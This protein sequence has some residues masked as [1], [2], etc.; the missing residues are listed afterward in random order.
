MFR[1]VATCLLFSFFLSLGAQEERSAHTF[2]DKNGKQ[3]LATLLSVSAD[4]R[5]MKIRREDGQEFEFV[6]NVLSLDDQQYIK[7][8]LETLPVEKTEYRLEMDIAKK[9]ISSDSHPYDTSTF[10]LEQEFLTYE[11]KVRNLS[12]EALEDAKVEWAV[13]IDDRVKVFQ[14]NGEWTYDRMGKEAE[15]PV[16]FSGEVPLASLPFNQEAIVT[17]GEVEVNE[18][19]R[20]RDVY[21]EADSIIGAV[22]RVVSK[23]GSVLAESRLGGA[24][25]GEMSWEEVLT[26]APVPVEP[27]D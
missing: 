27:A 7:E 25:F 1:F 20:D 3:I 26:M 12:R 11:V 13:V 10:T 8:Q 24:A 2:T 5:M 4:K 15:N 14:S 23:E 17:T 22:A 21:L 18:M 19:L 16:P 6:I 9:S